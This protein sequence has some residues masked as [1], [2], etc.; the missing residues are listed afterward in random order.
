MLAD[1]AN[2][3]DALQMRCIADTTPVDEE[4]GRACGFLAGVAHYSAN[5]K[6]RRDEV[7]AAADWHRAKLRTLADCALEN[8]TAL[9]ACVGLTVIL[10]GDRT[11][12]LGA[13]WDMEGR[14]PFGAPTSFGTGERLWT[15]TASAGEY[16]AER[17][18][19]VYDM[20]IKDGRKSVDDF[21]GKS[22]RFDLIPPGVI[23][24][25][26]NGYAPNDEAQLGRRMRQFRAAAERTDN[27]RAK[28][29]YFRESL[30]V[31]ALTHHDGDVFFTGHEAHSTYRWDRNRMVYSSRSGRNMRRPGWVLREH[32]PGGVRYADR[33]GFVAVPEA[34]VV[35]T[36]V[37]VPA[38]GW[39]A[40]LRPPSERMLGQVAP[41]VHGRH[42]GNG[43]W[44]G[45]DIEHAGDVFLGYHP[46]ATEDD[47]R[48]AEGMLL[49]AIPGMR[50]ESAPQVMAPRPFQL[51]GGEVP[52]PDED[53]KQDR[54]F[55]P[56]HW[57]GDEHR[58][59]SDDEKEEEESVES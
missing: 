15:S 54:N 27:G 12:Q 51:P 19:V 35:G 42:H 24:V 26:S 21:L 28:P 16:L 11:E 36:T 8:G 49:D 13:G 23:M 6:S 53:E 33:A 22:M 38:L 58:L 45:R 46:T 32:S 40:Q 30:L 47:F 1:P 7:K 17:G 37:S 44:W 57:R 50:P 9:T 3:V 14:A 5:F 18:V 52:W 41:D 10:D 25:A 56:G 43:P 34:Q 31:E 29:R 2:S 55:N 4:T 20:T 39:E 48:A 59:P